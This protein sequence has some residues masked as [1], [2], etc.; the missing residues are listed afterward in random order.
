MK[1]KMETKKTNSED[2][3]TG[4]LAAMPKMP[5]PPGAY[6]IQFPALLPGM[7]APPA[8]PALPGME[9]VPP[10][11]G[12]KVVDAEG[13]VVAE[14]PKI[15][16][17]IPKP[18]ESPEEAPTIPEAAPKE[19]LGEEEVEKLLAVEV[20]EPTEVDFLENSEDEEEEAFEEEGVELSGEELEL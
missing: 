20:T 7:P 1:R 3:L 19:K 6:M 9:K 10:P 17:A 8:I 15:A 12:V 14:G 2:V 5:T 11:P 18:P 4:T 13:K 16:E